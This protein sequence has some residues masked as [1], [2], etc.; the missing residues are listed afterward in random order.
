MNEQY[1]RQA[2][3]LIARVGLN[4]DDAMDLKRHLEDLVGDNRE[5]L[6]R[7]QGLLK[8]EMPDE[9]RKQI[10]KIIGDPDPRRLV[11]EWMSRHYEI[12]L[13]PWNYHDE[14]VFWSAGCEVLGL[15]SD[16]YNCCPEMAIN[17][18]KE[19]MNKNFLEMAEAGLEPALPTISKIGEVMKQAQHS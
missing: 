17:S 7:L 12:V 3:E 6:S 13:L 2:S 9:V 18:L 4:E 14:S 8:F 10:L 19:E 15:V 1:L 11:E 16:P 5:D